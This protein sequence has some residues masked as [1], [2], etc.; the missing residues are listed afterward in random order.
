[1]LQKSLASLALASTLVALPLLISCGDS[2]DEVDAS[3]I[4]AMPVTGNFSL[5]WSIVDG[6]ETIPCVDVGAVA[7]SIQLI[8]QGSGTGEA[9]SFPCT[10]GEATSRFFAPGIYDFTIDLRAAGST[11]LLDTPVRIQDFEI[12]ANEESALP[13]QEFAV[14]AVGNFNFFVDAGAT[15]G[16]CAATGVDGAGLVGLALGLKDGAG[17]CV[18][19]DFVIAAGTEAGGTY[20]SDCITPPAPFP[21]IGADQEVSVSNFA[22]GALSLEIVGQKA[23]PRDCYNRVSNFTLPGANLVKEL[24]SLLLNLELSAECDPDF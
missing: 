20:S 11:S 15:G 17:A 19:A 14:E 22:S 2:P 7:I 10:S 6:V 16:N 12:V 13:V 8:V 1:M 3:A 21:C 18:A 23:G 5:A 9:E 4:D 24:G